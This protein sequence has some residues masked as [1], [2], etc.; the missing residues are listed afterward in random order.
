MTKR[1]KT[2]TLNEEQGEVFSVEKDK[3]STSTAV[4]INVVKYTMSA[5]EARVDAS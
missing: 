5:L 3:T 2:V 1:R 4:R